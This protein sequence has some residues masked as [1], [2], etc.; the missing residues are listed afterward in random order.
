MD[1]VAFAMALRNDGA[2]FG[3]TALRHP[4]T[5]RPRSVFMFSPLLNAEHTATRPTGPKAV[6]RQD[7]DGVTF[8]LAKG[9]RKARVL[10]RI[11]S[12]LLE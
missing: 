5:M 11:Q 9:P 8:S 3:G 1:D 6:A 12:E 2:A 10:S 4:V 7:A